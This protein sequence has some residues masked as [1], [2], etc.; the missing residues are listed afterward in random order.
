MFG[1]SKSNTQRPP[2]T[3]S[4]P[5]TNNQK[6]EKDP[7]DKYIWWGK[8]QDGKHPL[9]DFVPPPTNLRLSPLIEQPYRTILENKRM[10]LRLYNYIQAARLYFHDKGVYPFL[11]IDL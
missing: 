5:N 4:S 2:K 11:M 1:K 9:R 6:K 10:T 8:E 7:L 3:P